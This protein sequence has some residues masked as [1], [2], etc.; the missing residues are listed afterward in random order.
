MHREMVIIRKHR[1][2]FLILKVRQ[3]SADI[4]SHIT[5]GFRLPSDRTEIVS[6]ISE[7]FISVILQYAT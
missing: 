5:A 6:Y 4:S 7:T 1:T 2:F 3:I